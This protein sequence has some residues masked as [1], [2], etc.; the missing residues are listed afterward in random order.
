MLDYGDIR[1][2]LDE[3]VFENRNQDYGAYDL[4]KRYRE[5]V[6]AAAVWASSGLLAFVLIPMLAQLGHSSVD[7]NSITLPTERI[8][9]L[10]P[11]RPTNPDLPEPPPIPQAP[12]AAPAMALP[13]EVIAL[14][15]PEASDL[16]PDDMPTQNDLKD[17]AIGSQTIAGPELGA[18]N[19]PSD[20]GEPGGKGP[21][22][23]GL[24]SGGEVT[25]EPLL[26]AEQQPEAGYDYNAYIKGNLKYP[27]RAVQNEISGT[28][29]VEFVVQVDGSI[30]NPKV[31]KGLGY[32][33]DEEALSVIAQMPA[34][35]PGK[36]GGRP[37]PVIMKVPI[38][39][40]LQ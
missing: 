28:V 26:F 18:E 16:D 24:V 11:P 5:R 23:E 20:L 15:P 31:L 2:G 36:Q 7:P 13:T 37:V 17:K 30:Q 27:D 25:V 6:R 14:T 32:D 35:Q 12:A 39:F 3:I 19:L 33:C 21:G 8:I 10:L 38:R 1:T 22:G 34:W 29:V 4:R 9:D 40:K